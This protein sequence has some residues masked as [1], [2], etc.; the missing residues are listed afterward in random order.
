MIAVSLGSVI[1][2][3]SRSRDGIEWK[4]VRVQWVLWS[5]K[6]SSLGEGWSRPLS[7]V[8]GVYKGSIVITIGLSSIVS[9]GSA[10]GNGIEWKFIGVQWVLWGGNWSSL[11]LCKGRSSPFTVML[12]V[13]ESSIMV[14]IGLGSIISWC[15]WS[16]NCIE[17]KFIRVQ[18]VLWSSKRCGLF[19]CK[20]WSSPFAIVLRVYE[21]SIV[22][23]I[24][25]GSVI[26]WCSA[27][28]DS[29]EWK[30]VWVQWVLWSCKRGSLFLSKRWSCPFSI[31]LGVHESS[32]MVS[33][34]LSS[35]VSWG[36][37]SR[38]GVEWKFIRVERILRSSKRGSSFL[39][40][41]LK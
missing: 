37:G 19:L 2:W 21:G 26:S 25:L 18:W 6:W 15:S 5:S 33:I 16:W 14:V 40:C 12:R 22:I 32:I 4:L 1:S 34:S 13:Y 35:I 8:L 3:S 41:N 38:N 27:S 39:R 23:A 10:S 7:I 29:I 11:F 28:R 30:L 36:S 24:S 20:R 9:W 31:V 17:W